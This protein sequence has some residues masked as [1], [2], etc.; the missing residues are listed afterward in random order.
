MYDFY[1]ARKTELLQVCTF[2]KDIRFYLLYIIWNF[3]VCKL[4]T[5]FECRW[6]DRFNIVWDNCVCTAAYQTVV[7]L[8]DNC[9]TIIS[10]IVYWILFVYCYRFKRNASNKMV[11]TN[12]DQ[13]GWY[14]YRFQ[15]GSIFK[16]QHTERL[17][18]FWNFR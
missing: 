7:F 11:S 5:S 8:T 4:F 16:C 6:R 13:T 9:I 10:R 17:Y 18:A 3:D 2:C 1:F 12:I 15:I 14:V